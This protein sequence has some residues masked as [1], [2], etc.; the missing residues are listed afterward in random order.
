[1]IK[2]FYVSDALGNIWNKETTNWAPPT[3]LKLFEK[4]SKDHIVVTSKSMYESY[5]KA[6]KPLPGSIKYVLSETKIDDPDVITV[7]SFKELL[8]ITGDENYLYKN[9]DIWVIGTEWIYKQTIHAAEEV[10]HLRIY[11]EFGETDYF[12]VR[13]YQSYFALSSTQY[14]MNALDKGLSY[15]LNC[16][17]RK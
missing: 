11:G 17:K 14:S 6:S 7:S 5:S 9:K 1:M 2:L 16:Y 4:M 12:N 8:D 10:Y 13:E 3:G 15:N